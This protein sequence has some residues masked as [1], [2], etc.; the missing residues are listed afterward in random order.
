MDSGA[1]VVKMN[2]ERKGCGTCRKMWETGEQP[3]RVGMSSTRCAFL[4]YCVVCKSYWEQCRRYAD[5]I[6][7]Q[8]VLQFYGEHLQERLQ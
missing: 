6:P 7:Y 8:E 5:I 4:H 3:R 2:W 1:K